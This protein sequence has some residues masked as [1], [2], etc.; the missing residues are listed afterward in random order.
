MSTPGTAL[1]M[2]TEKTLGILEE[3]IMSELDGH[4]ERKGKGSSELEVEPLFVA[5]QGAQG[6]GKSRIGLD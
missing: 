3:F 6:C 4:R 5:L 2:E 1:G